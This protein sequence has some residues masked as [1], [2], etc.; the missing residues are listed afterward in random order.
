[1]TQDKP[2]AFIGAKVY[3]VDAPPIEN[4]ILL[5]QHGKIVALGSATTVRL[6]AEVVRIDVTGKQIMPGLVD[7][8]SHIGEVA[9][10]DGSAALQ[11]DVRVLDGLNVLS[12]SLTRARA[13]GITAVNVMPGSGHLLS[14]Q[15]VYLKLRKGRTVYDLL[16]CKDVNKDICGGMKMAN[17][18]NPM[19]DNGTFPGTRARSAAMARQ[20]FIKAQAY[21]QKIKQAAGDPSKMPER[22]LQMEGLVEVL[23]GKRTVHFHTHRHDDILTAIRLGQEFGFTPVLQ[24]VSE[25][26]KVAKEIAA[27]KSPASVIMID[28]PGGKLEALDLSMTTG[29]ALVKEGVVMGYHTDDYVTDS[30]L[31]LRSAA[32]GIRAGLSRDKAL[33][34]MTLAGAKMLG[35]ADR[36][37]T[38]TQGK[39]ADFIILSGDPFSVYTRIEQTWIEGQKVFDLSNPEDRKIAVG[40]YGVLMGDHVHIHGIENEEDEQ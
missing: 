17:G 12:P 10:A 24:H 35:M 16:L 21:Q 7:T 38:L 4:A 27:S 14:G 30:R 15:T 25:G 23:E 1:M 33:E 20:L 19:R 18:T 39:D 5:V 29:A 9:G 31:F 8:H 3:P 2:H 13:G 36:I 40:A 6:S 28:S 34:A 22:D 37:G 32:L 11:P 26:W